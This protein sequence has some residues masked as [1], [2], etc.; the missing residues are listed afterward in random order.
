MLRLLLLLAAFMQAYFNFINFQLL[1]IA[2]ALQNIWRRRVIA[3]AF[4][5]F[6][7]FSPHSCPS[8]C[9][10][11]WFHRS[12]VFLLAGAFE[13]LGSD[14]TLNCCVFSVTDEIPDCWTAVCRYAT[15]EI[16]DLQCGKAQTSRRPGNMK[17]G[18]ISRNIES[19]SSPC[20]SCVQIAK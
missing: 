13:V 12:W 9:S 16:P 5:S 11:S 15:D 18:R 6:S 17:K 3:T 2:Y 1:I 10:S 8:T 4:Y 19:V 7:I 20:F 14:S